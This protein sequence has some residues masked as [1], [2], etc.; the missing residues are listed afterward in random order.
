MRNGNFLKMRFCE[1]HVKRI[2]VNQGLGIFFCSPDFSTTN[3][4]TMN[5]S[6]IIYGLEKLVN[7]KFVV[8]DSGECSWWK[9]SWLKFHGQIVHD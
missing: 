8:E 1:I 5:L 4:A 3:S 6:T 2:L 9:S 7:E